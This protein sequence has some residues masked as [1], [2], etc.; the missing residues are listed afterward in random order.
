MEHALTNLAGY[1]QDEGLL[2]KAADY[3]NRASKVS[4]TSATLLKVSFIQ[5]LS[6]VRCL[7]MR[8]LVALLAASIRNNVI[9]DLCDMGPNGGG[10]SGHAATGGRVAAK[11]FSPR[12][13]TCQS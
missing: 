12:Q 10:E 13:S 5:S 3:L 11:L 7:F 9:A 6:A 2:G 8:K 1:Y 4:R